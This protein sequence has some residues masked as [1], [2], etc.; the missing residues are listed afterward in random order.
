MSV[1]SSSTTQAPSILEARM[2]SLFSFRRQ[3]ELTRATAAERM[4]ENLERCHE[5]H[6]R[7][8]KCAG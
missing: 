7:G 5:S 4:R 3:V 8:G 6:H 1:T 2:L